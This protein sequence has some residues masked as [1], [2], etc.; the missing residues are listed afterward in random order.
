MFEVVSAAA[1]GVMGVH[2]W[3]MCAGGLLLCQAGPDWAELIR[4]CQNRAAIIC[5]LFYFRKAQT[6]IEENKCKSEHTCK[7]NPEANASFHKP[8]CLNSDECIQMNIVL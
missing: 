4:L 5:S 1:A 2:R 7:L 8:L 3:M 6:G